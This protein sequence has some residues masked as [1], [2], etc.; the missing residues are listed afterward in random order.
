[1]SDIHEN[2]VRAAAKTHRK[3]G[4][5]I[6]SHTTNDSAAFEQIRMLKAEGVLP[7]AFIWVHAQ[8]GG[9]Q[10]GVL[11]AGQGVWISCDNVQADSAN[12]RQT[13]EFLSAMRQ[14]GLLDKVMVSHDAGFYDVGKPEGGE[15]RGF[16]AVFT[17]LIPA[18]KAGGFSERDIRQIFVLNPAK[19]FAIGIHAG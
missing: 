8:A 1:L 2:L 9:I 4:L 10:S 14:A 5:A 17:H 3:T 12:I 6:A 11:A 19:A 13:V 18:L 15:F 7:N 16:T